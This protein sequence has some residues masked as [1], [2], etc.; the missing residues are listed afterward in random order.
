M[1]SRTVLGF[2][3]SV[4]LP[5]WFSF[6][7][8]EYSVFSESPLF[9]IASKV[10]IIWS[11]CFTSCV[12]ARGLV[13]MSE[14]CVLASEWLVRIRTLACGYD[15]EQFKEWL[16]RNYRPSYAETVYIYTKRYDYMLLKDQLTGLH[17]L[18]SNV[19][20]HTM[21]AL[22]ALSKFLG[23][24]ENYRSA[25]KQLGIKRHRTNVID[26]FK[27]IYGNGNNGN[28]NLLDW[29]SKVK[30]A[31]RSEYSFPISF[32]ALT[33]L[34]TSEA[35][36]SLNIIAKN[37][38]IDYYNSDYAVL[39]HFRFPSV[40][41]RN[42]KNCYIS[43]IPPSLLQHLKNWNCYTTYPRLRTALRRKHLGVHMYD[44]RSWN[45]T[46]LRQH[47]IETEFIDLVQGRISAS[48]FTRH[49]YRPNIQDLATR[50]NTLLEPI[51]KQLLNRCL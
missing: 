15:N 51:A 32:M 29:L 8:V 31:L 24:H 26:I 43:V 17:S 23:V 6:C 18:S 47:G 41:I 35:I 1:N 45:A 48:I 44:S 13:T 38:L 40:F 12:W 19:Q 14:G 36:D 22:S 42:T 3:R 39:E 46:F 9:F 5:K 30:A 10:F 33:G 2:S 21:N 25:L 37:G 16:L 20:R 4:F 34:R 7:E 50:V 27:H 49:Y 28:C 11:S